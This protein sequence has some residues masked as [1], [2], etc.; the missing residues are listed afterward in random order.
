MYIP[1]SGK[2]EGYY[3]EGFVVRFYKSDGT[4]WVANFKPGSTGLKEIHELRGSSSL[5]VI[6][7]G[8]CYIMNPEQTKPISVFGVGYL[9]TFKNEE[10][11][12]ILQDEIGL[13]IVESTGEYWDSERISWDGMKDL[14]LQDNIVTGLSF[15]P[16]HDAE[17][18]IDFSYDINSRTVT[19]GSYLRYD[20]KEKPW[21][22]LW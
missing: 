20:I 13:T 22:K 14:K 21:W 4:D 1:V 11:R 10:G 7:F 12:I 18:W 3:S 9:T 2:D 8:M 5:L 15:D 6:A 19:G 16:M 17:E